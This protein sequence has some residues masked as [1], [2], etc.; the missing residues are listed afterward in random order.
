MKAAGER[1]LP[2]RL[3]ERLH[4]RLS[5][6]TVAAVLAPLLTVSASSNAWSFDLK[7]IIQNQ[8]VPIE[9]ITESSDKHALKVLFVGN[10]FTYVNSLPVIFATLVELGAHRETK[11]WQVAAGGLTFKEQ[12]DRKTAI[13]TVS[14]N[15]PWD[16]VVL[17]GATWE[18][19]GKPE[20]AVPAGVALATEV[21][22]ARSRPILFENWAD[23]GPH[24]ALVHDKLQQ[25]TVAIGTKSG[26]TVIPVGDAW[27]QL[28]KQNGSAKYNI[29]LHSGDNHHPS[30]Q[31]A[32]FNACLLHAYLLGKQP[33]LNSVAAS[34]DFSARFK[35]TP[36]KAKQLNQLAWDFYMKHR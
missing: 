11:V 24:E 31:G 26:A 30:V 1:R 28:E 25:A 33:D 23:P 8:P 12:L 4:N 34:A 5:R 2:D 19:Y 14:K 22:K 13:E 20:N 17:Q 3:Q 7:Q 6:L 35:V 10:S 9:R 15:G 29:Q 36:D 21:R 18:I 16:Y 27:Y 32:F